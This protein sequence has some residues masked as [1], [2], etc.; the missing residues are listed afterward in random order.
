MSRQ[1][2]SRAEWE[3]FR[4]EAFRAPWL[5]VEEERALL[6]SAQEGDRTAMNKLCTCHMRLVVQIAARYQRTWVLPE[7]L[8]GEGAVGLVEAIRRFDLTQH[9]RLSTYAAWWIRARI[10]EHEYESRSL[11]SLPAT[12]GVRIARAQLSNAERTLAHELGRIP[13]RVE[14]AAALGVAEADVACVGIAFSPRT[15]ARIDADL[16]VDPPDP[17]PDPEEIA[18]AREAHELVEA[19]VSSSLATLA[20]RD[21]MIIDAHFLKEATS[22]AD[23]GNTLGITRQRVSQIVQ[24]LRKTLEND[25]RSVAC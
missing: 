9:T 3:R 6:R 11:V 14:V 16:T 8:V 12:R 13:T 18:A 22:M 2:S 23:L 24:R 19:S 5:D 15:G 4:A 17:R 1:Q 25:L 10:R 7:D 21:R 20:P